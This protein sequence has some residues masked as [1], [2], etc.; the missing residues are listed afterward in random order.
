MIEKSAGTG[1]KNVKRLKKK[2]GSWMCYETRHI[3]STLIFVEQKFLKV[4]TR[5]VDKRPILLAVS[6]QNGYVDQTSE[7]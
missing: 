4:Q 5:S 6:K 1:E 2:K 3:F 7:R